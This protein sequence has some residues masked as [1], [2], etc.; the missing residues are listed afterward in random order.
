MSKTERIILK[1]INFLFSFL[2]L[3]RKIEY[4]KRLRIAKEFIEKLEDLSNL[5]LK[6]DVSGST[7]RR[8]FCFSS[9]IDIDIICKNDIGVKK[10]YEIIH[11]LIRAFIKKYHY[12]IDCYITSEV[13]IQKLNKIMRGE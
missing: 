8:D 11:Y 1:L 13:F 9:D 3:K 2:K 5:S 4:K 10:L 12:F 6:Y 7:N